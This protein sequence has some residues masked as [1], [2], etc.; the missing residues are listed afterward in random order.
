MEIQAQLTEIEAEKL[1]FI[2]KKTQQDL[3]QILKKAIDLYYKTLQIPEKTPL[4][5][6]EES[7][8]IGCCSIESDLST[9]YKSVLTEKLNAKYDYC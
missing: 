9:T 3:I 1:S 7:G 5:I 6:L 8:F 4:E 2:Q